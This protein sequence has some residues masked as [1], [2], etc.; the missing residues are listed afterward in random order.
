MFSAYQTNRGK[1]RSISKVHKLAVVHSDMGSRFFMLKDQ[2][3][4]THRTP[5]QREGVLHHKAFC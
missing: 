2:E 4:S 1:N 5:V 3:Q